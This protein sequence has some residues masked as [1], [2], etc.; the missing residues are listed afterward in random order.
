MPSDPRIHHIRTAR[1]LTAL[2]STVRQELVAALELRGP[3]TVAELAHEL[4]R[5]PESLYYHVRALERVGLVEVAGARPS[6]TRNRAEYRL[7][8]RWIRTDP[9]TQSPAFLAALA[10]VYTSMLNLATG[11]MKAALKTRRSVRSGARRN[12]R[13]EQYNAHLDARGLAELNRRLDAVRSFLMENRAPS[14]AAEATSSHSV[15][16][17]HAPIERSS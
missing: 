11:R 10:R 17:V 15:T 4:A 12:L 3:S 16:L 13:V 2:E 7:R 1:E 6:R 14:E 8:K 5:K 9:A